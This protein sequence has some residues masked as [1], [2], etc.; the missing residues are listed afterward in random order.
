MFVVKV[1][2][3]LNEA[4]FGYF[5]LVEAHQPYPQTL[6]KASKTFYGHTLYLTSKIRYCWRKIFYDIVPIMSVN[7]VKNYTML[8]V[9]YEECHFKG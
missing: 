4:A 3:Y 8:S 9:V 2:A 7:N 1:G 5:T 6:D